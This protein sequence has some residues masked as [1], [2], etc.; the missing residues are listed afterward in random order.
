M[1]LAR[2]AAS[3]E[4]RDADDNA[5]RVIRRGRAASGRTPSVRTYGRR[6]PVRCR[7]MFRAG[8]EGNIA[9]SSWSCALLTN[10]R[11]V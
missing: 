1:D 8:F 6:N 2:S 5:G 3:T 7:T 4:Y 11:A 9:R 10:C